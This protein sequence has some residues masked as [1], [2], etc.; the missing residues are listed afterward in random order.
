MDTR[1]LRYDDEIVLS[2]ITSQAMLRNSS[3]LGLFVYADE[4]ALDVPQRGDAS[5]PGIHECDVSGSNS[6]TRRSEHNRPR[7]ARRARP[8]ALPLQA[9]HQNP[10]AAAIHLY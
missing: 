7:Q 3:G 1:P 8:C 9:K 4:L 6:D 2:E 5:T 10:G